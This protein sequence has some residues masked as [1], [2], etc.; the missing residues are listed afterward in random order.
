MRLLLGSGGFR[1][2][3][4]GSGFLV[5]RMRTCFGRI[6]RLLFVPYA[7]RD[8]DG[9]VEAMK[10]R[11]LDAG[12]RLEGIHRCPDPVAAIR[13]AEGGHWIRTAMDAL[14][15]IAGVETPRPFI[16]ST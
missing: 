1:T 4:A 13:E 7:L 5:E 9:Y 2:P 11:G 12:Y 8:H 3:R 10:G 15:P 16:A 14:Q 6:D